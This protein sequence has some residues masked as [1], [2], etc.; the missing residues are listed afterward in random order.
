MI[1][2]YK[3]VHVGDI[4]RVVGKDSDVVKYNDLNIPIA[5]EV[6][7][8]SDFRIIVL[9]ADDSNYVL[10]CPVRLDW[11]IDI[12]KAVKRED[13]NKGML[14]SI[15]RSAS[16]FQCKYVGVLIY[17]Q[18]NP[19]PEIIINPRGNFAKK[20]E[21]YEK[22]YNDELYLISAKENGVTIRITKA[23]YGDSFAEIEDSLVRNI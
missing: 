17:T 20:L 10:S 11:D 12:V 2:S 9:L 21:Y 15:F 22:A 6:I 7:E 3:D 13:F 16:E 14:T 1:T 19:A 8:V 23:T 5:G 4:I 18:G